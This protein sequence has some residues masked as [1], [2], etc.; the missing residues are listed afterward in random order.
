M[1]MFSIAPRASEGGNEELKWKAAL[2]GQENKQPAQPAE[3]WAKGHKRDLNESNN[4]AKE[5]FN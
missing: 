5:K 2:R 4:V 1:L 3:P